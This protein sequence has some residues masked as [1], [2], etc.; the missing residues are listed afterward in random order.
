[1]DDAKHHIN[2][3]YRLLTGEVYSGPDAE[4]MKRVEGVCTMVLDLQ[5]IDAQIGPSGES[6]FAR[7]ADTIQAVYTEITAAR[8]AIE[9]DKPNG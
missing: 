9:K 1:M 7:M 6:V 5:R 8:N 4:S 2:E 3:A